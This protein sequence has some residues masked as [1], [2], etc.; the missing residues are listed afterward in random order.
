[1]LQIYNGSTWATWYDLLDYPT[2]VNNVWCQ[3]SEM[4]SDPQYFIS[5]FRIRFDASALGGATEEANID[6][7]LIITD[8]IPPAAP[9]GLVATPGDTEVSLDWSDNSESD[10]DGYNVYRSTDSGGSPTPY[11]KVNASLVASSDYTDTGLTNDVTYYYVVTAVDL[12]NNESGDSSEVSAIP[13]DA[14]PAAPTGLVATAGNEEISLDWNDNSDGDIDG[15]NIYRS[16]DS[17]GS[18]TPYTKI[19]ISLAST[20]DYT[21]TGL[22]GGG[23]YYYVVTAV[24]LA[25]PTAYES[26]YSLEDSATANDVAPAA[27]TGLVAT[28]G[29]RQASLDWNDNSEDD[30]D[31]FNVHRSEAEGGP[32]SQVNVGLVATSDY[33][34]SDLTGGVTYYYVVT[35]LD[36]ANPTAYESGYSNEASTVP[37]DSTP[38]APTGLAANPGD[39]QASLDWNDNPEP[40]IDGYNVH[41]SED[42]GGPY[43]QVNGSLVSASEYTD[44]GLTGG[45]TYYYVVTAVDLGSNESDYSL[46]DN[47]T[48]T[49]AAPAAPTGLVAIPGEAEISLDWNDNAEDDIDG[50]NIHRSEALG[51]PYSQINVSLASTS[52]YTDTDVTN[53]VTYYYV[54]TAVDLGSNESGYSNEDSAIPTDAAPAAP[55]G[56][57][58]T[59]GDRQASLGWNDNTEPDI[60]GYNVY[61]SE[62]LGGPY[63]KVN[64]S[65]VASSD[66]TDTGL[67][68]GVTYYY[69]VTAVDLA[70]P[71]AYE[72]GDSNE[73]SAIP[74]DAT[75]VA[76]TGLVATK[77]VGQVSLDWNDN[78][79]DDI[80]GYNVYRSETIGGP[81]SQI[82]GSLAATSIYTDT[83]VT[84]GVTYYYV[85]TAV[86]LVSNES[87]YSNEDS[88]RPVGPPQTLLDDGFEGT[89]WDA[90]WDGNG[91]T[92]WTQDSAKPHTGTYN[93]RISNKSTPGYLTSDDLDTF[94]AE[95]ITVSFW[96]NLKGLEAGDCVLQIYNGSTWITW[97][98]LI[99][100]PTYVNNVWCQF[101]GTITDSQYFIS[102][103]RVRFDSSVLGDSTEE[104]NIDDVLVKTNQ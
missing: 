16:T 18:P 40:D 47:A 56:L 64:G 44:T 92:T 21:D 52:D 67:T 58:A 4:L 75:P 6:D 62:A 46:E 23:T 13:T 35:A 89:P 104:A 29:D 69:V 38:A 87:D 7:V 72:S 15:Y 65:L 96:F 98:D 53:G 48:P 11:S 74:F 76:P 27:P 22:Y 71:V 99:N 19:N 84:N 73:D 81:Y 39:R 68:G 93:A 51:G 95:N 5:G 31:G 42:I 94:A 30:I 90:N 43:S 3:F 45:V 70:D 32:Y 100:Y 66:Y 50:Y 103:F 88:A 25:D 86:D 10:L 97:Y 41:R 55:T 26:I 33:T 9:T 63:T 78:S 101:S 8:S 102:N 79:E 2:Y 34:D 91:T 85:V 82:N 24:D 61:R 37:T 80:D 28:P 36:E 14:A 59:P 20:S 49:D 83:D 54:V 60:A 12:G 17:G 77:G 1:V 57:V